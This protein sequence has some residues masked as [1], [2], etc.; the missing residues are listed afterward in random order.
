[1][2]Q[3]KKPWE[4]DWTAT[5][6]KNPWEENWDSK[7]SPEATKAFTET[8]PPSAPVSE[9][10]NAGSRAIGKTMLGIGGLVSPKLKELA[11]NVKEPTTGYGE[12]GKVVGNIAAQLFPGNKAASLVKG[13]S[14]PFLRNTARI[15]I[16]SGVSGIIG[17]GQSGG[18]KEQGL[19]DAGITAGMGTFGTLA[20]M[21]IGRFGKNVQMK[22]MMPR[23]TDWK[24]GFDYK[25]V[26][27]LGLKGNL[28]Q[29]Y[30][31]VVDKLSSLRKTR[32]T[33]L[34]ANPNLQVDMGTALTEAKQELSTAISQLKHVGMA[35]KIESVFDELETQIRAGLGPN[36]E[37]AIDL[38]EN[39]KE[40]IGLL[41]AWAYGSREFD[42]NATEIAAN[43]LYTKV[44]EAIERAIPNKGLLKDLNKQMKELIPVR[45]AMIA[46][47]PVEERN[48][49]ASL[50]D[51]TAMLPTMVTGNP[52]HAA[53]PILTRA[54]KSMRFGNFMTRTA[55]NIPRLGT[56]L[57]RTTVGA[58]PSLLDEQQKTH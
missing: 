5:V 40:S 32:N 29:S 37:A 50:A 46:R 23:S 26:A 35:P 9:F 56:N 1:M 52:L 45:N 38:A 27:K 36:G 41:G 58:I 30:K 43:V 4:E 3:D 24:E 13:I 31:Q 2:P 7:L 16:E 20:G 6:Q 17:A 22:G 48:S 42:A 44:R 33:L 12:A 14:S 47:I 15:G 57:G 10:V 49:I 54:Q 53:L 18:D 51:I 21:A 28:Q 34:S 25:T 19:I 39:A 8:Q 55:P 11:G